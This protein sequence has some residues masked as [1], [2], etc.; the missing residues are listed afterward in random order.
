M[1]T[2]MA[3]MVVSPE[4]KIRF[5]KAV[6]LA[7]EHFKQAEGCHSFALDAVI[8]NEGEYVLLVRW[9]SVEAHMETFRQSEGFA[10]WRSLVSEFFITPPAVVHTRTVIDGF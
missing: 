4:N 3:R 2:E 5:E 7:V 6:S 10:A 8:E 9:D 1:V